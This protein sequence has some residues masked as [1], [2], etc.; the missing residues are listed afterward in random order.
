MAVAYTSRGCIKGG[1]LCLSFLLEGDREMWDHFHH[2]R[3]CSWGPYVLCKW[4]CLAG[5]WRVG[6][7]VLMSFYVSRKNMGRYVFVVTSLEP[8]RFRIRVTWDCTHLS[9]RMTLSYQQLYTFAFD[10]SLP[11]DW[12][13]SWW[14]FLWRF[15]Y[16]DVVSLLLSWANATCSTSCQA[17]IAE[18]AANVVNA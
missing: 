10:L 7:F 15:Y 13:P 16:G 11:L 4:K 8:H 12:H 14:W 6:L 1:S 5:K 2:L 18:I 3:T 17:A 9:P